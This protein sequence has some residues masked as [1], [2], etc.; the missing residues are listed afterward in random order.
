MLKQTTQTITEEPTNSITKPYLPRFR[1]PNSI[2]DIYNAAKRA[3]LTIKDNPDDENSEPFF[4]TIMIDT[5]Q[6]ER[7]LGT[8]NTEEEIAFPA[9][10]IRFVN[11]RYLVSQQRVGEGRATMRIR[12]VLNQ[13]N[14]QDAEFEIEPFAI[15]EQVNMAIQDAKDREPALQERCNLTF[16]DMPSS[17]NELQAYWV[18]YEVWFRITSAYKYRNWIERQVIVPPF[19]NWSDLACCGIDKPNAPEPTYNESSKIVS[20]PSLVTAM[21][22]VHDLSRIGVGDSLALLLNVVPEEADLSAVNF[23]SSRPTVVSVD[24]NGVATGLKPGSSRIRAYLDNGLEAFCTVY[25]V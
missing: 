4:K 5:G 19:T 14:N 8:E 17:T 1:Q 7:L 23:S 3:L 9:C 2:G 21:N 20:E 18:D 22:F 25:V 11:V 6:F 16:F 12:F 13:L 10:F 24:A 15:F